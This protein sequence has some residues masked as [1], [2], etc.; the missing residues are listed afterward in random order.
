LAKTVTFAIT[1]LACVHV[2]DNTS[3]TA[4]FSEEHTLA[5]V[6]REIHKLPCIGQFNAHS[7]N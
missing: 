7:K 6:F 2:S 5:D 1:L 3:L 4:T